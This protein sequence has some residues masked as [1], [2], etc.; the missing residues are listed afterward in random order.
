VL[1]LRTIGAAAISVMAL[2]H[3][4]TAV[5][6]SYWPQASWPNTRPAR[7]SPPRQTTVTVPTQPSERPGGASFAP[8]VFAARG[9]L[10][11][12]WCKSAKT[13]VNVANC[14][15]SELRSL[16]IK[17]LHAFD[18]AR[19]R[20]GWEQ[21]T[22]LAADQNGWAFALPEI[23]GL[24]SDAPPAL[25]LEPAL[26]DCLVREGQSRLAYLQAY[27]NEATAAKPPAPVTIPPAPDATPA[28][29][30]PAAASIPPVAAPPGLAKPSPPPQPSAAATRPAAS[31]LVKGAAP[32]W[33]ASDNATTGS[34]PQRP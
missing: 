25:P 20:L 8:Q 33:V 28:K 12:P 30:S 11:D 10:L 3:G 21:Q 24:A 23:C 4:G 5:A 7:P 16:A 31:Q 2:L 17:R 34:E 29:P 6:Q 32:P 18:Q 27:G 9:D 15:D 14:G 26:K 19:S 22:A 1:P 13:A